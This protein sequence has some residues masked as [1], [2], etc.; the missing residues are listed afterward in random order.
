[1]SILNGFIDELNQWESLD[2]VNGSYGNTIPIADAINILE[3]FEI[4][5]INGLD[6][7]ELIHLQACK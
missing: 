2:E 7:E 3:R 5:L 6:C 4:A 1:M